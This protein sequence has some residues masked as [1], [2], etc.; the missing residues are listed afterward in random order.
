MFSSLGTVW[1]R[2]NTLCKLYH[3]MSR[4]EF[5]RIGNGGWL[6]FERGDLVVF[7]RA[8]EQPDGTFELVELYTGSQGLTAGL[9]A[10]IPLQR[11][12]RH[13]NEPG[14]AEYVRAV[15]QLPA[16]DLA[17]AASYYATTFGVRDG[18][19]VRP[20]WA[21]DMYWSQVRDSGVPAAPP[22][23]QPGVVEVLPPRMPDARLDVPSTR[24]FPESF[25]ESFAAL[26]SE[27]SDLTHAPAPV[28]AD[29]NRVTLTQV[30]RWVR[31]ARSKGL[32]APPA[33]RGD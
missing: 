3:D 28:I 31:V 6:R 7:L 2:V 16:V 27:L 1:T 30:H 26:Y 19:P 8:A 12:T 20:H 33:P 21:A 4:D 32:L 24:P 11:I 13:I 17:T 9:L 15:V 25:Y 5:L 10:S 14:V 29:A 22:A 18:S 23:R